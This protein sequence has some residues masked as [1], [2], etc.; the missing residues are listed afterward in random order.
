MKAGVNTK[1][2]RYS[3]FIE[4]VV[5]YTRRETSFVLVVKTEQNENGHVLTGLNHASE[6]SMTNMVGNHY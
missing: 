1:T 4:N 6:P 2:G 5:V 3:F